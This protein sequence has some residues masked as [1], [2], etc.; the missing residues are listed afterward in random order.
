MGWQQRTSAAQKQKLNN[1]ALKW[2]Q[3]NANDAAAR[4]AET[5]ATLARFALRD[6]QEAM[7]QPMSKH[8]R[9][10][11]TALM[12][13]QMQADSSRQTNA[14]TVAAQREGNQ[15]NYDASVLNN[16]ATNRLAAL[17]AQRDQA[18]KDREYKAGRSDKVFE[19]A[20]KSQE[21]LD[22][23]LD[24]TFREKDPTTGADVVSTKR[25]GEFTGY[26]NQHLGDAIA[27]AQAKG[28]L[29]EVDRLSRERLSALDPRELNILMQNFRRMELAR[30]TQGNLYGS[31]KHVPSQGL[32][33][34]GVKE[35]KDG[36]VHLRNGTVIHEEKMQYGPD[37]NV[38]LPNILKQ[39][40]SL[41]GY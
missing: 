41:Y 19:Q 5:Q 14:N 18:N 22:K 2:Q 9:A 26:L 32:D 28:D 7:N 31:T 8:R 17:N 1:D 13:A 16:R 11:M 35:R 33:G 15:L 25:K 12:Q 40:T 38:L 21:N 30:A 39:P 4:K 37:G 23:F 10:Q 24:D 36:R 34:Y 3:D 29:A 20:T 6:Q 27:K